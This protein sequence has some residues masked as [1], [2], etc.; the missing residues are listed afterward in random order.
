RGG[1]G[2]R[3][4]GVAGAGT[5]K[6]QAAGYPALPPK[7]GPTMDDSIVYYANGYAAEA[8]SVAVVLGLE[9]TKIAPMPTDPG[10]PIDDAN[11][12]AILGVNS[13]F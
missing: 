10:I 7:N 1:N 4:P 2:A 12:I 13:S 9:P 6:L 5:E 8:A 11:V 3:R